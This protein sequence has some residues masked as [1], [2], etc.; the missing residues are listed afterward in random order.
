METHHIKLELRASETNK[1]RAKIN[2]YNFSKM[3]TDKQGKKFIEKV[4]RQVWQRA[5]NSTV[6]VYL[7]HKNYIEL[8]ESTSITTEDDGVYLEVCLRDSELGVYE[9]VKENRLHSCSFGFICKEANIIE[10][11]DFYERII[12]N[13]ELLE[14]SLLDCTAA[15]NGTL[16]ENRCSNS[17]N[18][19]LLKL[20]CR[21]L[22][23][24]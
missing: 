11:G 23:I 21:L 1:I 5:I 24:I 20:K 13:M 7:N 18:L 10:H 6:K 15:Y 2:D 12:T 8:G 4:P 16:I 3:L 9:A 17:H 22:S 19:Q 14:V